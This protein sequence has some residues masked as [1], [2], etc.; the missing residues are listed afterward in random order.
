MEG[1]WYRI[2]KTTQTL[3]FTLNEIGSPWRGTWS[4]F[5]LNEI[6]LAAGGRLD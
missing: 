4:D 5:H 1:K 2:L 3:T 6:I